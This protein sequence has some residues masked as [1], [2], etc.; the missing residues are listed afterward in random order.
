MT[1]DLKQVEFSSH[2]RLNTFQTCGKLYEF[3]YILKQRERKEADH[4]IIGSACH[5]CIEMYY[6]N[7]DGNINHPLDYVDIYFRDFLRSHQVGH[8]LGEMK[9]VQTDIQQLHTR[10]SADYKGADA[11]RKKGTYPKGHANYWMNPVSDHPH[12]TGDWK[13]AVEKLDLDYRTNKVDSQ[14]RD[15]GKEFA[16]VSI[17]T[18]YAEV[19]Q[20]LKGYKDPA[21]LESVEYV[22]FPISHRVMEGRTLKN[23]INPVYLP[24]TNTLLN[25]YVDIIGK[26]LPELGGGIALGD[27]KSSNK[28]VTAVEVTYH[29]QLN[30]YGWLWK[31][32]TGSWP[33]HLF[34]NNLRFGTTTLAEFSP[35]IAEAVIERTRQ[36]VIAAANPQNYIRKDPFGYNSPCMTF[37]DGV[38]KDSCP[39]FQKCHPEVHKKLF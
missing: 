34:I 17:S 28:E 32:L 12:F 13:A 10:A 20:I 15:V 23:V 16:T 25:G 36:V 29:E 21:F 26:M 24:G 27:Y 30:K 37:K 22:E 7:E 33:T 31:Q 18:C 19:I 9:A 4:F 2:S 14:L 38:V 5:K 35:E 3:E 11:I 1:V 6:I 8:L 39:H